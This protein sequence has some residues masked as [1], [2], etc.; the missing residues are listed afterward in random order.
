M[1]S[2]SSDHAVIPCLGLPVCKQGGAIALRPMDGKGDGGDGC[3]N[4]RPKGNSG[5]AG[6]GAVPPLH[7]SGLTEE[8][9]GV[10]KCRSA[11]SLQKQTNI[12]FAYLHMQ[13]RQ[14]QS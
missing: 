7:R 2:G 12:S 5:G 1:R 6:Q 11:P 9:H 10:G 14:P 8:M 3:C 4:Q 13:I